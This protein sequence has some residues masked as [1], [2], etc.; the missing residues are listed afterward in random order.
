MIPIAA[1][2]L[3]LHVSPFA[4]SSPPADSARLRTLLDSAWQRLMVEF[5]EWATTAGAPGRHRTWTD[6]SPSGFVRR[7]RVW[8]DVLRELASVR[9]D[10]LNETDRLTY[11]VAQDFFTMLQS[12]P[13]RD[14]STLGYG[15][16]PLTQVDGAHIDIGQIIPQMPTR[17][18]ADY[19]DIVARLRA[20]PRLVDGLI[21]TLGADLHA[22]VTLPRIVL[23][24]VPGQIRALAADDSTSP[25]LEP[26]GRMPPDLPAPE[27]ARLRQAGASAVHDAAAPALGR[28]LAFVEQHY[29][30]GARATIALS[31]LPDGAAWYTRQIRKHT[32]TSLSAAEIHQI[33]L[34]EVSR[35]RAEMDSLMQATGFQGTL[36]QFGEFLRTDPRFFLPDARSLVRA[37]RDIAKR[38]D[39]ELVRLFGRL[40]RL[41]YG[42]SP[43]PAF[44]EQSTTTA[45]YQPGSPTAGRAGVYFVNTYD[46]KSRPTWEMEALSMHE[47][48]PGHHLQIALAQELEG[49]PELRRQVGY[50]AFVEGWALYAETLGGEMGFYRDPYARFGAATYQIWRA[51][52]LVIDTGIHAMGWTRE[53]AIAYFEENSTKP[54]HDIVV[55]VDRYIAWPGQALGYMLGALRIRDLRDR[56]Q[57]ALGARFDV[58]AFHDQVLGQGALPLDLLQQRLEAWMRP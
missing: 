18:V 30:P 19:E 35:L 52:R 21:E 26:F 13:V 12:Q 6:Y 27:R 4:S 9:R 1:L 2:A 11:D 29:L 39:P 54:E 31:A 16:T 45:Y 10:G 5:P 46:L 43:V 57:R 44:F 55:E 58:R 24:D 20:V 48:V 47:A 14:H 32:T 42:V 50:N 34:R 49:V 40:P 51:I 8:D 53:Q 38:A 23:R 33:G 56:A 25:L 28:L 7:R 37:Y 17:T 3:L 36:A 22:G 41:P 15:Y